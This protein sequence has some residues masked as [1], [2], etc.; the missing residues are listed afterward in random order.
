MEFKLDSGGRDWGYRRS[1]ENVVELMDWR[2]LWNWGIGGIGVEEVS[3]E[4]K[5][6]IG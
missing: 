5:V 2:C 1:S 3:W 4:K 6:V